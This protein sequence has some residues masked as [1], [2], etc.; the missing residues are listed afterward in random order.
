MS[1]LS[2]YIITVLIWGSTWIAI[3]FQ[4]GQVAVEASLVYRFALASLILFV[5]CRYKRLDLGFTLKQHAYLVLFGILNFSINYLFLYKAQEY[6][7]SALTAV[8][9]SLLLLIN[10][11]NTRLFFGTRIEPKVY[12]GAL[13]GLAGIVAVFWPQ[14]ESME[15]GNVILLNIGY[16]LLGTLFASFGN[17]LSARNQRASY[18]LIQSNAWSMGYGSLA[19]VLAVFAQGKSLN[20]EFSYGY[21]VSLLYLAIFGSVIAFGAYF[22]LLG[23]IGPHKASYSV[24]LFPIVA[25]ILSSMFEGLQWQGLL[26]VGIGLI[27]AGNIIVLWPAVRLQRVN[28]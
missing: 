25:L 20:F 19:M 24:V 23:R 14:L 11:I 3:T 9:F 1:N 17:I 15:S 12:L 10:I 7:S 5:Y 21:I 28:T 16:C 27:L 26:G 18:P 13:L 6:L 8:L 4:L 2:L 22:A